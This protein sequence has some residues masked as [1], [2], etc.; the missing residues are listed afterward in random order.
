MFLTAL[1]GSWLL[2]LL[3]AVYVAAASVFLAAVY[4]RRPLSWTQEGLA[5]IA[6]WVAAVALWAVLLTPNGYDDMSVPWLWGLWFG[7]V[8]ATPSYVLWQLTALAVRLI[9][10]SSR[11]PALP[12]G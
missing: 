2:T 1:Y 3:G 4:A 10:V 6:R 9:Y 12:T 5:W 7:L 8:V 11:R